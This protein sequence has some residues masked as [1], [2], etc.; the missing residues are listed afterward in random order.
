MT[1]CSS[2][3]FLTSRSPSSAICRKHL[4][5]ALVGGRLGEAP[6]LLDPPAHL[7]YQFRI[8]HRPQMGRRVRFCNACQSAFW[9]KSASVRRR[10]APRDKARPR[11]PGRRPS[12]R[13]SARR[14]RPAPAVRSPRRSRVDPPQQRAAAGHRDALVDDVGGDFGRRLLQR[15]PDRVDDLADRLGDRLGD[16]G[17]AILI[18][19]RHAPRD[20]A[21]AQVTRS[22]APSGAA[23]AVRSPS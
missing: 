12:R 3:S 14:P 1:I 22:A 20:V 15:G 7:G 16:F 18:S 11:T 19:L 2:S 13:K 23:G 9:E 17:L 4:G 10:S 5:G 21:A 6:A 8:F